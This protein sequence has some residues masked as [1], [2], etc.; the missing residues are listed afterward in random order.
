VAEAVSHEV[1]VTLVGARREDGAGVAL[2]DH[3]LHSA[4]TFTPGERGAAGDSGM[5]RDAGGAAY[6][7]LRTDGPTGIHIVD[8]HGRVLAL[9]SRRP[10]QRVGL[11]VLVTRAAGSANEPMILGVSLAL[12]L[13]ATGELAAWSDGRGG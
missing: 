4:A 12:Q 7:A 13:L 1:R 11:D 5:V 3:R 6:M 9:V 8:P 10:P 2:V